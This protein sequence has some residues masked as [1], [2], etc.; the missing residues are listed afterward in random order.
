DQATDLARWFAR[1]FKNDSYVEIQNNGLEIQKLCA[2]G[3]IA[4]ADKLGLPLVAT[5][6]AHYLTKQ[7]APAHDVLLCIN[8]GKIRSDPNRIRYGS[9]QFYVRGPDEM[10]ELFPAHAD[11][12]K[13]SQE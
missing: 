13:R 6:D 10:Y 8:T 12:V 7:D 2:D 1:I 3:A 9:E 4:I 5:C 11:A